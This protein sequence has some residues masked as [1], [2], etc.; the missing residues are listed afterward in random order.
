MS[1]SRKDLIKK[2]KDSPPEMGVYRIR[3]TAT[4]KSFIASSRNVRARLN[5][6]KMELRAGSERVAHLQEDWTHHGPEAFEFEILDVL[7]P[8][9]NDPT[10]DPT[11][12]L[13]LLEEMWREKEREA[14]Q[15]E[16]SPSDPT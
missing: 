3:N 15:G 8:P 7:R 11:D 12:E 13:T 5:R 1:D 9:D 14:S 4:G 2:Y 6:H 16:A 10:Y